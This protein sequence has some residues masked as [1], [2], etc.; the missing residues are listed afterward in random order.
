M[1]RTEVGDVYYINFQT[2]SGWKR[3]KGLLVAQCGEG[4]LW[5]LVFWPV[6][7]ELNCFNT[8]NLNQEFRGHHQVGYSSINTGN[9]VQTLNE[10]DVVEYVGKVSETKID[11][12]ITDIENSD[13][14]WKLKDYCAPKPR[15]ISRL[16]ETYTP[17]LTH[18]LGETGGDERCQDT[19]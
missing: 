17:G 2:K 10:A 19:K 15:L 12:A 14:S 3:G 18:V 1:L 6:F 11:E 13:V 7:S 5:V 16:Y 9:L 4:R 8:C